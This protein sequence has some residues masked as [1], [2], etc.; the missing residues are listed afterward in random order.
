MINRRISVKACSSLNRAELVEIVTAVRSDLHKFRQVSVCKNTTLC[1][2]ANNKQHGGQRNNRRSIKMPRTVGL[3]FL[4]EL[5]L[6][7]SFSRAWIHAPYLRPAGRLWS[8]RISWWGSWRGSGRRSAP[9]RPST[10]LSPGT[11]VSPSTARRIWP[12]PSSVPRSSG[13]VRPFFPVCNRSCS[14][15]RSCP[16][17]ASYVRTHVNEKTETF[18]QTVNGK[19]TRA[20]G[21]S[22][23]IP[24]LFRLLR[25]VQSDVV[26]RIRVS[27]GV[28]QPHVVSRVREHKCW[29]DGKSAYVIV[30]IARRISRYGGTHWGR[31]VERSKTN[32]SKTLCSVDV[33]NIMS[34]HTGNHRPPNG[35]QDRVSL[36]NSTV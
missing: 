34:C 3:I 30:I 13:P 6:P 18:V 23:E 31:R 14:A 1:S 5:P 35:K 19:H 4:A 26:S 9:S 7:A 36:R 28:R 8:T 17:R 21:Y 2:H 15:N 29:K 12:C 33:G 22:P 16:S 24:K 10:G 27:P 32:R 20:D 11:P 25:R